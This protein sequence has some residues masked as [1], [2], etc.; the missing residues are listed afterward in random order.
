MEDMEDNYTVGW[1]VSLN[2]SCEPPMKR[3]LLGC[4]LYWQ[5]TLLV[6]SKS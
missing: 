3:D 6:V 1:G 4:S 5:I 2:P